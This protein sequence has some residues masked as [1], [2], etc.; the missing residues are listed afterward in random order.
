MLLHDYEGAVQDIEKMLERFKPLEE[1]QHWHEKDIQTKVSFTD[2]KD[3]LDKYKNE[4]KS[5]AN[6]KS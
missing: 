5:S 6:F 4:M 2:L 1:A 3:I